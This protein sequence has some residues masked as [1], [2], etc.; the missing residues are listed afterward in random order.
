MHICTPHD[1][2]ASVAADCLERGVHV[3][4]EKPLAHT[5]AEGR[6]LVDV[7]SAGSAKIAVCFQNRYNATSQAMH[8]A[9]VDPA[10]WGP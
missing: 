8:C 6:R 9:A 5:L 7:A 10:S 1:Q 3:I 2:H 4:V